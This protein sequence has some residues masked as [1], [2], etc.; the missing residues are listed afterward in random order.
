MKRPLALIPLRVQRALAAL[1]AASALC[2]LCQASHARADASDEARILF[3]AGVAASRAERWREASEYFQRSLSLAE[4]PSTWFNLGV[5]RL[6]LGDGPGALEAIA[7]F[8]ASATR[9]DHGDLIARAQAVRAEAE[10]LPRG[11]PAADA[12]A[13]EALP[14][15]EHAEPDAHDE[16]LEERFEPP[17]KYNPPAPEARPDA[18][19]ERV[20]ARTLLALGGVAA[21][22]AV[23][24][25]F[26]WLDSKD[27]REA[28]EADAARCTNR[29]QLVRHER[30]AIAATA[31]L[32]AMALSF[33]ATG[34]TLL[35]NLRRVQQAQ[36]S[37]QRRQVQVTFSLR[38]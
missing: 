20:A 7:A 36:V 34:A 19:H 12:N 4:K 3:E 2:F 28:C 15:P 30:S 26:W 9:R 17:E 24:G 38:F 11:P 10:S 37:F 27:G 1:L 16:P 8:E 18:H 32:S 6:R 35:R 25:V 22:S 21:A 23:A 33:V 5:A 29:A 31:A 14:T 13:P